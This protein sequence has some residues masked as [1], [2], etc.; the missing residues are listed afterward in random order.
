MIT[1]TVLGI[2]FR[3]TVLRTVSHKQSVDRPSAVGHLLV[4]FTGPRPTPTASAAA[5][6]AAPLLRGKKGSYQRGAAE[7]CPLV[8]V[9]DIEAARVG[10]DIL[11][12]QVSVEILSKRSL[13]GQKTLYPIKGCLRHLSP[14][15]KMTF[16]YSRADHNGDTWATRVTNIAC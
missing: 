6:P 14:T 5:V 4:I 10:S 1:Q 13:R 16:C 2:V 12:N 7:N 11:E 3:D 9:R 8:E 15:L